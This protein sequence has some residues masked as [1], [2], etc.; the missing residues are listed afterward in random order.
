V[1]TFIKQPTNGQIDSDSI[2]REPNEGRITFTFE[3][4]TPT[5]FSTD[6]MEVGVED[7]ENEEGCL[8]ITIRVGPAL[9]P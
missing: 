7:S 2:V 9:A 5:D 1:F 6:D 3:A 8:D 4:T